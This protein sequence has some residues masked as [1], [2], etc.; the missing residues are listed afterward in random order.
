[1][2]K[3]DVKVEEKIDGSYYSPSKGEI[4]LK[5]QDETFADNPRGPYNTVFH[6]S[7]H[8]IDDYE[9]PDSLGIIKEETAGYKYNGRTLNSLIKEDTR[10]YVNNIIESDKILSQLTDAQKKELL[11]NLNLTDDSKYRY[12]GTDA[13]S[14]AMQRY[15]DRLRNL[16]KN[17]LYG[18]VNECA[19]DVYGGV[20]NNA[21]IGSYGHRKDPEDSSYDYWYK[22]NPL[23]GISQIGKQYSTGNQESEMWAEFYAAKMTR[24]EE[25]LESIRKH[26]PQAYEA[27]EQMAADMAKS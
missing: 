20:T 18:P 23:G 6:E 19:S 3:Y 21:I 5:D 16:M 10:N 27:M 11:T 26:F 14:K 12:E 15:Q 13:S 25:A 9:D 17:D 4:H 1:L 7:G 2:D 22:P 24:D 8:A